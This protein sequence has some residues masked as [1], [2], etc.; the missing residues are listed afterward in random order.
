MELF[1]TAIN[2]A[3]WTTVSTV[4]RSIVSLLQV[5]ILTGFL[6]K[7]DFGIVAIA[8]LFIG[9]SNIFLDLGI[10]IGILHKQVITKNEYSSLFWLNIFM[11]LSLTIFLMLL[12]PIISEYYNDSELI[13]VLQLLCLSLFFSSIGN[14]HRTVQQKKLR[15]KTIS[16]IE[17]TSSLLT[18]MFAVFL[19]YNGF[20][21]YSLVYSTLFSVL[22]PNLLFL[23]IGII[24]DRIICFHFSFNETTPFLRIGGYNVAAQV[25]D[26]FSREIDVIIISATLG[27]EILGVYSLCKKLVV[28]LFSAIAP[29]YNKVLVPLLAKLQENKEHARSVLYDVVESVSITNS[30][31]FVSVSIFPVFIITFLY[32]NNY[33]DG[34]IVL[35]LIAINYGYISP[36]SSASSIQIAFGRTDLGLYWT[37]FR[38]VLY[39]IAAYIGSSVSIEGMVLAI[40]ICNILL[41]PVEWLITIRPIIGGKFLNYYMISYRPF[42]LSIL[43]AI[44]FYFF[45]YNIQ[46]L[47]WV[48]IYLSLYMML[49]FL[50]VCYIFKNAYLLTEIRHIIYRVIK[51][52][53]NN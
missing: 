9:F 44:P 18:I 4:V 45:V 53:N 46:N 39:A 25:L 28:S 26:Y 37:C 19:A 6:D 24:Q 38:I 43:M 49:Y 48:I 35:S 30:P 47:L 11:G 2:G 21:V 33:V 8:L 15:F 17:I 20:K 1:K 36:A 27:K 23:L 12:A 40:L 50:T 3:A 31:I 16:F 14:E 34:A 42:F 10:S 52:N 41:S 7:S 5:S 29:V 51:C 13:G 32:G 22:F